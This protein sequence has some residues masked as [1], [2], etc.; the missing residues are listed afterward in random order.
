MFL[1]ERVQT[2]N[3]V[4]VSSNPWNLGLVDFCPCTL[5]KVDGDLEKVLKT[6]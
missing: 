6:T 1:P 3:A 4:I 2:L 5:Y